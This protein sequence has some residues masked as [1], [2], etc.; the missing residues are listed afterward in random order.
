MDYT[1]EQLEQMTEEELN[2]I[3]HDL[4]SEEAAEINN[5]GKDA[6]IEYILG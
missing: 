6:Q 1:R 2:E 5:R 3:V 4:K